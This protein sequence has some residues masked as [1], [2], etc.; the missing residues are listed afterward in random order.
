DP[1][2]LVRLGRSHRPDLCRGLADLLLVDA[3]DEDLRRDRNLEADPCTGLDHDLVRIPNR[4]LEIV[5]AHGSPVADTLELEALLEALGHALDHVRDERAGE[6]VQRAVLAAVGRA[7]DD[8]P[9]VLLLDLDPYRDL[10]DEL[11]E[12]PGHLDAPG[13]DR[14]VDARGQLDGC[15][16]DSAHELSPPAE[17]KALAWVLDGFI[18]LLFPMAFRSRVTR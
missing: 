2:A 3:L 12:W 1:L 14:D 13:E 5:A 7:L 17:S 6:P 4:E 16:S 15:F 11:P 18:R 8:Q 9:A 10:L